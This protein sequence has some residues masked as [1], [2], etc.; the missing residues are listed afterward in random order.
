MGCMHAV[1]KQKKKAE[2]E[3]EKKVK[4]KGALTLHEEVVSSQQVS[5]GTA[6][7]HLTF[8]A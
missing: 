4:K 6:N 7:P 3:K 5:T 2:R 1:S 8:F